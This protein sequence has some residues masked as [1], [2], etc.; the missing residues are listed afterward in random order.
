MN[1]VMSLSNVLYHK[2]PKYLQEITGKVQH[3]MK[4]I[5]NF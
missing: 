4:A 5:Y 2:L 1:F 3:F